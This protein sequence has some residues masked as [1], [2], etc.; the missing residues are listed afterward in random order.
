MITGSMRATNA[1]RRS[2]APAETLDA[3]APLQASGAGSERQ[4]KNIEINDKKLFL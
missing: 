3:T 2:S 4:K 1:L